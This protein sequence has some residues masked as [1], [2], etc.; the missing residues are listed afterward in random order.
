MSAFSP[1]FREGLGK[2]EDVTGRGPVDGEQLTPTRRK[3]R[4][5]GT[6]AY[7]ASTRSC[8]SS[9]IPR[10]EILKYLK[11]INFL[12]TNL[13]FP[14]YFHPLLKSSL[15]ST[16]TEEQGEGQRGGR[17]TGRLRN[18]LQTPCTR[19]LWL[20]AFQ[21]KHWLPHKFE[22]VFV[23]L[24]CSFSERCCSCGGG[25]LPEAEMVLEAMGRVWH[26][27]CFRYVTCPLVHVRVEIPSPTSGGECT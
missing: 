14:V 10:S 18:L 26:A 19:Y 2:E 22:C 13:Q 24:L 12:H 7:I 4:P 3:S 23:F 5:A 8:G 15:R 25:F 16:G 1:V 6:G 17:G 21:K 27:E 20:A 9:H 11:S